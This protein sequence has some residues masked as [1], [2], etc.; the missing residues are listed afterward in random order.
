MEKQLLI[1]ED[2]VAYADILSLTVTQAQHKV[3]LK[4]KDEEALRYIISH[5]MVDLI[6]LD[7]MMQGLTVFNVLIHLKSAPYLK[8][9]PVI[10][11]TGL[12]NSKEKAYALKLGTCGC[13]CK[14]YSTKMSLRMT[15]RVLN[16][17][18][19]FYYC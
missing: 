3:T 10:I 7:L 9:I 16:A 4:R 13:V 17:S 11:Q 14:P 19:D 1:V 5:P 2:E 18:T 12:S 8:H 15:N 6:I